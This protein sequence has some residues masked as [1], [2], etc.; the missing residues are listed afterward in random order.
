MTDNEISTKKINL[1]KEGPIS[2]SHQ[3][4]LWT[5]LENDFYSPKGFN[6]YCS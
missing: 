4:S 6:L 5:K 3:V 2:M 1:Q